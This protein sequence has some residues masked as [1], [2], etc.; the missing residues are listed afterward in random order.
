MAT[1]LA[2]TVHNLAEQ[3]Q[4]F[5]QS[6]A[7]RDV[8]HEAAAAAREA[9]AAAREEAAAARAATREGEHSALMQALTSVINNVRVQ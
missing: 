6:L 5:L 4:L 1:V 3:Q 2:A 9:A 7:A 8:A